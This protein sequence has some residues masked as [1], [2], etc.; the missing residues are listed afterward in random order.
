LSWSPS[1]P[2]GELPLRPSS[3][4]TL[5]LTGRTQQ[6]A[7]KRF[8][9]LAVDNAPRSS[10]AS[11]DPLPSSCSIT[12]ERTCEHEES[13]VLRAE[14][15]LEPALNLQRSF[16]DLGVLPAEVGRRKNP[17]SFWWAGQLMDTGL[18]VHPL[19]GGLQGEVRGVAEKTRKSSEEERACS[20]SG[21]TGKEVESCYYCQCQ[22]EES[23]EN[24]KDDNDVAEGKLQ[25]RFYP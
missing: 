23:Q 15:L 10:T 12:L 3:N 21:S 14:S 19:D 2:W 22:K 18:D 5:P 6:E 11:E 8:R 13:G 20:A 17:A 25:R 9:I 16:F 1:P 7:F 24:T 4:L